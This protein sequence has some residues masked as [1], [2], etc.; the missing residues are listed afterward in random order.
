M[1]ISFAIT[2]HNEGEYLDR[3]LSQLIEFIG[4]EETAFGDEI[5][6]LDDYSTDDDTAEIL[7]LATDSPFVVLEQRALERDFGTHKTY[8]NSLCSKDYIFQIDADEMLADEL[9][10]NLHRII[11]HNSVDMFWIPRVNTV[12]GLTEEHIRAWNWQVNED[13]WVLWPDYQTRLYRNVPEIV[14]VGKVH[15]RVVGFETFTHLPIN[16]NYALLHHKEI[17]R[18]EEQNRF[19]A[20]ILQNIQNES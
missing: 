15:E 7:D 1:N 2:T 4:D 10:V 12:S 18:Q 16:A 19:Y 20:E 13:G 5:V 11:E 8:L 6:I 14:W 17:G 3:L 9:L